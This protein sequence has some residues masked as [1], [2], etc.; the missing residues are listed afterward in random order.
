MTLRIAVCVYH[1]GRLAVAEKYTGT[2]TPQDNDG[3][4]GVL[5][6]LWEPGNIERLRKGLQHVATLTL[7]GVEEQRTYHHS[8]L[9]ETIAQATAEKQVPIFPDVYFATGC[10][11][12][13][14][15]LVNL[16]Q[17]TFEVYVLGGEGYVL[18]DSFRTRVPADSST[19]LSRFAGVDD[20]VDD[21]G[22]PSLLKRFSFSQLP[23]TKEEF[24][25]ALV[26]VINERFIRIDGY[27]WDKDWLTYVA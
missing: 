1:R 12:D 2:G 22:G 4:M 26:A 15:Y 16:D 27:K 6:F 24:I 18:E 21:R 7:Q 13:W 8:D 17:N 3:G 20:H 5:R 10:W 11:C 9:L 23:A 25:G 19:Q 14:A